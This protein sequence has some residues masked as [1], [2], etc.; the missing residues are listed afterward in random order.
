LRSQSRTRAHWIASKTSAFVYFF[1]VSSFAAFGSLVFGYLTTTFLFSK[2]Y[3]MEFGDWYHPK[4]S[5]Y[6]NQQ[7]SETSFD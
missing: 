4:H 5:L 1:L 6:V 7:V 2:V 3:F